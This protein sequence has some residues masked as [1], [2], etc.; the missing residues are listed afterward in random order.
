MQLRHPAPEPTDPRAALVV[1][2]GDY[3]DERLARLRAP[4]VDATG[5]TEVLAN[6]AIGGFEVTAVA[7]GAEGEVR[8]AT[9]RFLA[10]RGF[11]DLVVVYLSC[12]GLLD[13]RGRLYFAAADTDRDALASTAVEARWLLERL[14]DCRA[15]RQ[16][17]VLD[18]C[19]SGAFDRGAKAAETEVDLQRRLAGGRGRA[20]LTASRATE[21]SFE[22]EALGRHGGSVFTAA[23]VEG[24]RTG[25]ADRDN[26][27]YVTV[28]DAFRY[29]ADQVRRVDGSAQTPQRWLY[30]GEDQIVL[31]RNPLGAAVVPAPLPAP[32]SA[33]LEHAYPE[34][35]EAGVR[36]LGEWLSSPDPGEVLAAHRRLEL[37][38]AQDA[39]MVAERARELLRAARSVA[40]ARTPVLPLYLVVDVSVSM[41]GA[42][43]DAVNAA[44]PAVLARI[45]ERLEDAGLLRF[46]VI[47]F[48]TDARS[49]VD[50]APAAQADLPALSPRGAT[51]YAAAFALLRERID[52]D[53]ADLAASAH[54]V[55]DVVV[56][57]L[58]DGWPTDTADQWTAA[59]DALVDDA[60]TAL[61]VLA[62]GLGDDFTARAALAHVVE[63]PK[64]SG[65]SRART[66]PADVPGLLGIA[67]FYLGL[68]ADLA[69]AR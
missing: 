11:D 18:C 44:V 56:A 63:H 60:P 68:V 55:G 59:F 21:Y 62:L 22:G 12:H 13:A 43:I 1:T 45:S 24:L 32:L 4:V 36:K 34:M 6:P 53:V 25:A 17:L 26:T 37:V 61:T 48:G 49:R 14:D 19:F 58:T 39:P 10:A 41:A 3:A 8:R 15:G 20:V 64:V 50:L 46:G 5:M 33:S 31:A 42:K 69:P 7:D 9:D 57:F 16:V 35:R 38:A 29:A 67:D 51:S 30:H 52:R 40:P 66:I 65:W 47:D 23:L 54:V 27:G 28:E 2:T